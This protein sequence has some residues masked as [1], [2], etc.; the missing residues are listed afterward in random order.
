MRLGTTEMLLILAVTVLL[1]G[2]TKLP[3]LGE[4]LGRGIRNFKKASEPDDAALA[5]RGGRRC[6]PASAS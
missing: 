4:A 6:R 2:G 1:F 3:Q 5:P